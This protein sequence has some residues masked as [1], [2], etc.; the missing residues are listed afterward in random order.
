M[1]CWATLQ[2]IL[3]QIN[4]LVAAGAVIMSLAGKSEHRIRITISYDSILIWH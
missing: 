1:I 3:R 4:A 2:D